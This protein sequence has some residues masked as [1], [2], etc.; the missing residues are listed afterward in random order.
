[1]PAPDVDRNSLARAVSDIWYGGAGPTHTDLERLFDLYDLGEVPGGSKRERVH[2]AVATVDDDR[3]TEFV[4]ALLVLAEEDGSF[5][6]EYQLDDK[7][8]KVLRKRLA[9][10]HLTISATGTVVGGPGFGVDPHAML[11]EPAVQEHVT[12][13]S[14]ALV[15]DDPALVLGTAK[16]LLETV[17]KLVLDSAGEAI[18]DKFPALL[19]KALQSLGL[20]AKSVDGDDD[21]ADATRRIL[22]SLQQIGIGVNDLRNARGTGHGRAKPVKLSTRHARLAGGSAVVLATI[23]LDTFNDPDTPRATAR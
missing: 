4:H 16:E 2:A 18:P 19:A 1:M 15:N 3:V 6:G 12:R 20:H 5:S 9:P 7:T 11:D 21:I 23:M 22:G 17:S 13:L 14:L 10:L 8:M